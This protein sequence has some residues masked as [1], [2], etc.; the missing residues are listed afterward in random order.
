[1]LSSKLDVYVFRSWGAPYRLASDLL[2]HTPG[3]PDAPAQVECGWSFA[4]VLTRG[5]SVLVW[6]PAGGE[7]HRLWEADQERR[8]NQARDG[9][10]SVQA[11]ARSG[12][13]I[14]CQVWEVRENPFRLGDLP[15]D[16]PKMK[17]EETGESE[18]HRREDA[19]TR[20]VRIAALDNVVIALTNRGHVL[21]YRL[22]HEPVWRPGR[23][24]YVSVK[25]LRCDP[26]HN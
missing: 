24:E 14:P 4:A 12:E 26:S 15:S 2:D 13:V 1:M 17:A 19:E 25:C 11:R 3:S 22:E 5:G 16:L 10:D 18:E 7:F 8:R 23:W 21:R 6:W 20:I 9:D